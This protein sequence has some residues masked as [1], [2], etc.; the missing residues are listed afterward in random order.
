MLGG[1]R[2]IT[3]TILLC[4]LGQSLDDGT[5]MN[6]QRRKESGEITSYEQYWEELNQEF[7]DSRGMANRQAWEALRL[8]NEGRTT[9]Q[10]FRCFWENFLQHW[11]AV[12]E[13]TEEEARRLFMQRLPPKERV[14]MIGESKRI[15][16]RRRRLKLRGWPVEMT[17][18]QMR[19]WMDHQGVHAL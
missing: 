13:A 11:G 19:R 8:P 12:P 4:T 10:E 16:N 6:L 17:I 15:L 3:D 7:G 9:M 5:R 2:E 1:R 14:R 18:H